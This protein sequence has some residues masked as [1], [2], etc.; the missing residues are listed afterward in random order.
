MKSERQQW[1]DMFAAAFEKETGIKPSEACLVEVRDLGETR[2]YFKKID[3]RDVKN[4]L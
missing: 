2:Y 1:L 3:Q 4:E